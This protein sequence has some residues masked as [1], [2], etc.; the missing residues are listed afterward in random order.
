[1]YIDHNG[2]CKLDSGAQFYDIFGWVQSP[3]AVYIGEGSGQGRSCHLWQLVSPHAN[4][5]LCATDTT[6][7][8][9]RIDTDIYPQVQIMSF[10]SDLAPTVAPYVVPPDCA[11]PHICPDGKPET[12]DVR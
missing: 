12:L 1:M 4:L 8:Y 9:Q 5:T 11:Q 10:G 3:A 2:N 7:V 6:P